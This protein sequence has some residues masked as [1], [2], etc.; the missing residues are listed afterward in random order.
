MGTY[1]PDLTEKFP[2]G[3]G[4]VDLTDNYFPSRY[5]K[6][7]PICSDEDYLIRYG[8]IPDENEEE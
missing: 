1:I 6:Y 5:S 8:D 7:T 2:E 3:F 4:G